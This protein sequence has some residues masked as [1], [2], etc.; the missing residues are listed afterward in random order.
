MPDTKPLDRAG[1][2]CQAVGVNTLGLAPVQ[3]PRM[4]LVAILSV[5]KENPAVCEADEINEC[6][7]FKRE[8]V[9]GI[10]PLDRGRFIVKTE[11]RHVVDNLHA[12]A[13][14]HYVD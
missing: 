9:T 3:K 13:C 10:K 7:V 1:V 11:V 8:E 14:R 6:L 4:L 12:D 5:H 2:V